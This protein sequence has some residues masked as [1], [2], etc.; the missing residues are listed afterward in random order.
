MVVESTIF[1]NSWSN[2]I[3]N[4]DLILS[5]KFYLWRNQIALFECDEIS[6]EKLIIVFTSTALKF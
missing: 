5:L 2:T 3:K 6:K 4:M 1:F